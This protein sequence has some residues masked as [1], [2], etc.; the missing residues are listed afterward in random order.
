MVEPIQ[1]VV[2]GGGNSAV[3][4]AIDLVA[5]RDGQRLNFHPPE[6]TNDVTLLVRTDFKTDLKFRNKLLAYQ[7]QDSGRLKIMFRSA[8][9]EIRAGEVVVIDSRTQ[10]EIATLAN[11]YVFALVGGEVRL[12]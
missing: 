11:D 2:V 4:A 3:E 5:R 6:R 12:L 8:V 10:S 7:C 1:I 9:K